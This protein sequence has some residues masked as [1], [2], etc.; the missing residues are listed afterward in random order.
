[1]YMGMTKF[2]IC[3]NKPTSLEKS[4]YFCFVLLFF[5]KRH[6]S[7]P[8]LRNESC[9]RVCEKLTWPFLFRNSHSR[10]AQRLNQF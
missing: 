2:D 3:F 5:P 10:M 8:S 9:Y 4:N 6:D 1:M 7:K